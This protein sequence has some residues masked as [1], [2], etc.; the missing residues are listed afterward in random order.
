MTMDHSNMLEPSPRRMLDSN[1]QH[2]RRNFTGDDMAT[3][4]AVRNGF[5]IAL[6]DGSFQSVCGSCGA[7]STSPKWGK[8]CFDCRRR[9]DDHLYGDQ[10]REQLRQAGLE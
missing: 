10:R 1:E 8:D 3:T 9:A 4:L 6:P 2:D 5:S 7:K